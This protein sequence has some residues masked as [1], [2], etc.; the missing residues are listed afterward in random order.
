MPNE[1]VGREV[2]RGTICRDR[3]RAE[4]ALVGPDR[5][6][7]GLTAP[8]LVDIRWREQRDE[9]LVPGVPD[10]QQPIV[11]SFVKRAD[12]AAG[13]I[14]FGAADGPATR[15]FAG[16]TREL[17]TIF[18]AKATVGD[19]DDVALRVQIEG[20]ERGK[21]PM[22]VGAPA[23]AL[24]I[25]AADGTLA[26]ATLVA[27]QPVRLKALPN[28]AGA[29]TFRWL[30]VPDGAVELTNPGTDG[31]ID[32]VARGALAQAVTLV[33]AVDPEG[34]GAV[35]VATHVVSAGGG[36]IVHVEGAGTPLRDVWIYRRAAGA[37]TLLRTDGTGRLVSGPPASTKPADYATQFVPIPGA[38]IELAYSRG[39][40]PVPDALVTAQAQAFVV[41]TL[42]APPAAPIVALPAVTLQISRPDDL[43][44]WP[45]SFPPPA[46][47]PPA[48]AYATN[49]LA[50]AAALFTGGGALTVPL[51]GPA[52]APAAAARPRERPLQ[53]AGE[54]EA[55]ATAVR[56]RLVDG[57][58][59]T[60]KIRPA[61]EPAAVPADDL[62]ATLEPA[63]GATRQFSVNLLPAD[64]SAAFGIVRVVV[65]AQGPPRP[66]FAALGVALCGVQIALVADTA[67]ATRGP[68][69]GEADEV[70][71]VDFKDSPQ[72]G[73]AAL[74]G[75]GR[76][77]RMAR[78]TIATR[79]RALDPDA[80]GPPGNTAV[81][82][83]EMP[84]WMAE[85]QLVGITPERLAD[86]MARRFHRDRGAAG[87]PVSLRIAL[88]WRLTLA[89]DG[90]DAGADA[91][92][93]GPRKAQRHSYRMTFEQRQTF[94][95]FFGA[96]GQ[97][98]D[99]TGVNR[100]LDAAGALPEAVTPLATTIPFPVAGR[101]QAAAVMSGVQRPWGRQAGAALRPAALVEWQ[102]RIVDAAGAEV[103]RGGDGVLE[104]TELDIEGR[105]LDGESVVT[106]AAPGSPLRLAPFR[107]RG[108]N[109]VE[110]ADP[111]PIE[112]LVRA[113]VSQYH[114]ANAT[115]PRIQLLTLECWQSTILAIF[116]HE[117]GGRGFAQFERRGTLR[118]SWSPSPGVSRTYGLEDE[119]PLFGPPHG[120]GIGQLDLIFG[121]GPNDDEVWS[122]VENIRSGV[123]LAMEE[124]A[125][126]AYE[127]VRHHLPT[128]IDRR[129]RAVYQREIVRRYN[130]GREFVYNGGWEISP[131]MQWADSG[132]HSKGPHPNLRYP[133]HVLHKG[134]VYFTN[135]AGAANVAAGAATVFPSPVVFSAIHYGDDT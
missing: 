122:F 2:V 124:K 73:V 44:L 28:P 93:L 16:D 86:L 79:S 47:A 36:L 106:P 125:I 63:S 6:A 92:N 67:P 127:V 129:T 25:T 119:M 123:R 39:A 19:A 115:E 64:P 75:Q 13:E 1:T 90:P 101:R 113:L 5:V 53:V 62:L 60:L 23:L 117:S 14:R 31:T 18:G 40:V 128:P 69:L 7:E 43:A 110:P 95:T 66:A 32:V 134:V 108:R 135:P 11:L 107:V 17:L 88:G 61:A 35:A 130:G 99:E 96:Q 34:P 126:A 104:V 76:A 58:G 41:R 87:L 12:T 109:P 30:C 77:R 118:S 33:A 133:D 83:P 21:L 51:H 85:L 103:M 46:D 100:A 57:A 42:P 48:V 91:L 45:V 94:E 121:R 22:S 29:G 10:D 72:L 49:G 27:N 55:T 20:E 54:A 71:E 56:V 50:Q 38:P 68:V 89:W 65:I 114:A 97:F 8:L 9:Q 102:P 26:P 82:R 52:P 74:A 80:T 37:V 120:Y 4:I 81:L 132:D 84:L 116:R 98:T 3:Y 70:I 131:N 111:V 15:S 59:A 105:R 24:T 112:D 78:Y